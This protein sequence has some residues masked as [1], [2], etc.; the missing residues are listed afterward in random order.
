MIVVDTNVISEMLRPAPDASVHAW[1][2]ATP[3]ADLFTTSITLAEVRY[4]IERLPDGRRRDQLSDTAEEVFAAF[5][6]R[7]LPFDA[8]ATRRYAVIMD[9]RDRLGRPITAFD[10][11]IAS[12]CQAAGAS[13]ATRN[14]RDFTDTGI[15]LI[16]PWAAT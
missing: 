4:G 16:D 2:F 7:V 13:L 14:T 15:D 12:I 5:E 10:A 8:A 3:S 1:A 9:R 6:S 11:Q